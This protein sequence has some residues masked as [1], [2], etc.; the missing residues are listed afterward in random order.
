MRQLELT[1]LR[2]HPKGVCLEALLVLRGADLELQ[3]EVV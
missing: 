3:L 2:Q 1:I